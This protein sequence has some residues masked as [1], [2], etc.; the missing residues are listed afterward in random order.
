MK[1]II[2]T[3]VG[4]AITIG[5][6]AAEQNTNGNAWTGTPKAT[7]GTY[8]S[9]TAKIDTAKFV[10]YFMSAPL[11]EKFAISYM[12]DF[13]GSESAKEHNVKIVSYK[14]HDD[15]TATFRFVPRKHTCDGRRGDPV[16]P[17]D[18]V[19]P[20]EITVRFTASIVAKGK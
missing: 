2:C 15:G 13:N 12:A 8:N 7:N 6:F 19:K 1:K 5:A 20:R 14:W 3:I 16:T 4:L 10:D 17:D 9:R 11:V 18:H